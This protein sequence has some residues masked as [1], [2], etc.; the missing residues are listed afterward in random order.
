MLPRVTEV[1]DEYYHVR[2]ADPDEFDSIRTPDW[3]EN[4]ASSV[5]EGA[6]VRTG[7]EAEGDDSEWRIQSILIPTNSAENQNDAKS[8]AADIVEKIEF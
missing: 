8:L 6:E 2:Y 7:H 5:V 3:A 4:P 1:T